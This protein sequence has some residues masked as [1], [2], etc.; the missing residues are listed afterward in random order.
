MNL[1]A[2]D[3]DQSANVI[4]RRFVDDSEGKKDIYLSINYHD[5]TDDLKNTITSNKSRVHNVSE[6][7]GCS[8]FL[9]YEKNKECH[10]YN[11]AYVTFER[12]L[13]R[14]LSEVKLCNTSCAGEF[15][16]IK[17]FGKW[18]VYRYHRW[19]VGP[20]MNIMEDDPPAK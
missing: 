1:S 4:A 14:Y 13:F 19:A 17:V 16:A 7:D 20:T 18:F 2:E 12:M 3:L 6:L 9:E 15:M 8:S 10:K 11:I 5:P